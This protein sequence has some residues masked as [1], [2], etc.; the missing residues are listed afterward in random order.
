MCTLRR[1]SVVFVAPIANIGCHDIDLERM[2]IE[3]QTDN[4]KLLL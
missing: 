1:F 2:L 4:N 3:K